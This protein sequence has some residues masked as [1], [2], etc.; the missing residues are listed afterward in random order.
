MY[1]VRL[2]KFNFNFVNLTSNVTCASMQNL[3]FYGLI[4]DQIEQRNLME[5][6]SL[7]E[8]Y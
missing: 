5:N 4:S 2:F 1:L 7:F 3:K 6:D 8:S